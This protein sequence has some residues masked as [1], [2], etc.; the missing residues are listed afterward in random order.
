[1]DNTVE[2]LIHSLSQ[3]EFDTF[4]EGLL[5]GTSDEELEQWGV[6][7]M[8]WGVRK[9]RIT[10]V[11]SGTPAKGTPKAKQGTSSISPGGSTNPSNTPG[12]SG[13]RVK[14]AVEEK[15]RKT[16]T[17]ETSTPVTG[18]DKRITAKL[19]QK[20]K[21]KLGAEGLK[22]EDLSVDQLRTATERLKLE[23]DISKMLKGATKEEVMQAVVNR[24]K[25]E[26]EYKRLTALPPTARQAAMKK[27]KEILASVIETQTKNALNT[28]MTHQT[29]KFFEAHGISTGKG[30]DKSKPK[31][32][33]AGFKMPEK[34]K[35]K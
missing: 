12:Q 5:E 3:E 13:S 24:I 28:L 23:S 14:K 21:S 15:A 27:T 25:L 32:E 4:A 20:Q 17:D 7:G 30:D 16:A 8:R 26:N 1:M 11:R 22:L 31:K 6:L 10:G 34:Q 35:K 29:K 9:S 2:E 33:P 18:S 19:D